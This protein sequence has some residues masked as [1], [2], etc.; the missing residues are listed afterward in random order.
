MAANPPDG[1]IIDYAL[2]AARGPVTLSVFDAQNHN[3]RIFSSADKVTAA[4]PAKL[5]FAPE[6]V[7]P[8]MVLSAAPGMHRFVWD[9]HYPKPPITDQNT[10]KA[11]KTDGIWAPPGHYTVELRVD[12]H[13]Y[14]Q[15]LLV[16]PDPRVTVS[17]AALR[18]EFVLAQKVAEASAQASGASI[19]AT[20]LLNALSSRLAHADGM[21]NQIDALISKVSDLSEVQ[22][23]PDPRELVSPPPR[24][25]DSLGALSKDLQTLK[26]AVDGGDAD[27]SADALASYAKLSD[28][29]AATLHAWQQLKSG[30]LAI[31]N[32]KLIAAGDKAIEL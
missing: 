8:P 15:P 31:L 27:P 19:E 26:R 24:R 4:D 25:V 21:R 17:E 20:R 12:G 18:R 9:L 32:A 6:W 22:L 2:P 10:S 11:S 29:L 16:K 28:M 30:D 5:E 14:E 3:V 1:A 13:N 7:S 23:H